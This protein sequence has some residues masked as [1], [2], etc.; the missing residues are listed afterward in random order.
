MNEVQV[1]KPLAKHLIGREGSFVIAEWRDDGAPPEGP[2]PIAPLHVHDRCEEAWIVLEGRLVVRT[3]DNE[4][5]LGAGDAILVPPGTPHTFW[6]PDP[7][8]CR[9]ILVMTP[10]TK[11]LIDAIHAADDRS[12]AAMTR[13]FEAHGARLL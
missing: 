7:A 5:L 4:N 1:A 8:P 3:G 12:P 11:R 6:N 9:Y 2:M 13:L 10:L